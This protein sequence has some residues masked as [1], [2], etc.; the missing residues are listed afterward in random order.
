MIPFVLYIFTC[1]FLT[2]VFSKSVKLEVTFPEGVDLSK[3]SV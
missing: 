3:L 2:S 1:C